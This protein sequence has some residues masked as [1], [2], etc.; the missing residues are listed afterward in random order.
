M[1]RSSVNNNKNTNAQCE[2]VSQNIDLIFVSVENIEFH[3]K[4]VI[5]CVAV[6]KFKGGQLCVLEAIQRGLSPNGLGWGL[7]SVS[8]LEVDCGKD[9]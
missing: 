3:S 9:C 2:K 5:D 4:C 6:F 1:R 8:N 7:L